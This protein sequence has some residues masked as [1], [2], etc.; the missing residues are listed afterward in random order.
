MDKGEA[1]IKVL[2]LR[3]LAERTTFDG[4]RDNALAQAQRLEEQFSFSERELKRSLGKAEFKAAD[5]RAYERV[6]FYEDAI[7]GHLKTIEAEINTVYDSLGRFDLRE[8]ARLACKFYLDL[9]SRVETST[10]WRRAPA[11]AQERRNA[12]VKAFY[13]EQLVQWAHGGTITAHTHEMARDMTA[14]AIDIRSDVVET[15]V[16]IR[17]DDLR[18][19][20]FWQHENYQGD[21]IHVTRSNKRKRA[22]GPPGYRWVRQETEITQQYRAGRMRD[23]TKVQDVYVKMKQK[24]TT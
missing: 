15:I 6:F 10:G 18:M 19:A 12:I 14:S 23:E 5:P 4:E 21:E 17:V 1:L 20:E 7:E 24:G 16:G 22:V 3:A 13:E 8:Q 11:V 9:K 2:A